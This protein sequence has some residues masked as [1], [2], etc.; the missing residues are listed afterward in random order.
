MP[1]LM[2]TG[3]NELVSE[4]VKEIIN[5]R[6]HW[7]IQK[8]NVILFAVV[9]LLLFATW[10]IKYPD[11]IRGKVRLIA[12]NAPKLLTAKSEGRLQ[13]LLVSN[14]EQVSAGQPLAFLN[15]TS[16]HKQVLELGQ[17]I[18]SLENRVTGYDLEILRKKK[19]PPLNQLGDLQ[20]AFNEF[21]SIFFETTAILESGFY[22]NKKKW[23]EKDLEYLKAIQHNAQTRERLMKE[24]IDLQ[25]IEY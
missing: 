13:K 25:L 2:I 9:S 24:D 16:N 18:R 22:R 14:E 8:G 20:P 19:L 3:N 7:I 17:W 1:A 15:S 12:V 5:Y 6:P 4:D 10:L 11:I 23:L 21:Q